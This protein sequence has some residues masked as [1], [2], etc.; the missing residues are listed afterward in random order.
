MS[1]SPRILTIMGS[2]ETAPTMMK[3]H[4][5]LIARF[6]G[7]P[8]AVVLD[9]PYGFQENAAELASK[10]VEYFRKSV[11]HPIEIAG[12]TRLHDEDTL[13]I[14]QGL[15]RVR[16]ADY[17]FAGPGSPTYAL[18]QWAGT[19]VPDIVRGKMRTGGA[20]TFASAAALT[21][22]RYTVPVYEIY[23]VGNDP[24]WLEG[25]DVLGEIG[26]NVA[27]IPHYDNAEGG[28]HD[29]RFCYMGERRLS[30]LE[31]QLPTDAHVIGVDEHTGVI[32]DLDSNTATVI[33]NSTITVRIKGHSTIHNAGDVISIDALRDPA[34]GATN[35]PIQVTPTD[36]PQAEPKKDST[37]L[38]ADTHAAERAFNE[39]MST[40]DAAGAARAVL[41]LESA[42][43]AWSA[44][45]LQGEEMDN[46]H[47]ALRSMIVRLGDA[48]VGGLA[49]PRDAL[50]PIMNV[51]LELRSAVR[52]D[53]RY[54]LSDLIRDRLAAVKIEV[55]DTPQG[56]EWVINS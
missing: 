17:V 41:L 55:R 4:R 1:P 42:I 48:A 36:S 30:I 22:G 43:H 24:Y 46:A 16:Q 26:L 20:V 23:K 21:L 34:T 39:A 45:T 19:S 14:E 7:T 5:E 10:A 38:G 6:P 33:G 8:K 11:G 37:S 27:V 12:L 28:H 2:G 44:D 15:S 31:E 40:G 47:A 25:L 35:I 49:D 32:L 53:K 51:L 18:R 9:T 13:I 52:T 29:T 3:H 50:D 54:D 56:V